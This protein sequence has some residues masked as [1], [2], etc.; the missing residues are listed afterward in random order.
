MDGSAKNFLEELR[1]ANIIKQSKKRNYLKVT[2]KIELFDGNR[3][4]SIEP[5][6]AFEVK[7]KLN[8]KNQVI[9]NQE[10]LINF[11]KDNLEEVLVQELLLV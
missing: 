11:D 6:D 9:G 3:K 4:I 5:S 7:F 1:S 8:Y 10:N 2:K